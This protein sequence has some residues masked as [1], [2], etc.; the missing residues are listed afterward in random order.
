M[1]TQLSVRAATSGSGASYTDIA[2]TTSP[3]LG[4]QFDLVDWR[5]PKQATVDQ[6]EPVYA[7]VAGGGRFVANRG[8]ALWT[9]TVYVW[10]FYATEDLA[11]KA[12][13]MIGS[14]LSGTLDMMVSRASSADATY[15]AACSAS[16]FE[17]D[18]QD[19][20]TGVCLHFCLTF[21]GPKFSATAP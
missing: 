14:L 16:T 18:Q 15:M 21:V 19:G 6:V 9:C 8:N 10:K 11:R 20:Q 5:A 13:E 7:S 3:A 2:N 17:P 1:I 12:I 4:A